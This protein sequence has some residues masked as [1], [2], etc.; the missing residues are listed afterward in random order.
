MRT[1]I[2]KRNYNAL[3]GLLLVLG[4][5][6]ITRFYYKSLFFKN[7]L[8]YNRTYKL[9]SKEPYKIWSKKVEPISEITYNLEWQFGFVII[10]FSIIS[11]LLLIGKCKTL[12]NKIFLLLSFVFLDWFIFSITQSRLDCDTLLNVYEDDNYYLSLLFFIPFLYFIYAETI[13]GVKEDITE[14][15]KTEINTKH[16][17][18]IKDLD[19]LLEL[20]LISQEEYNEKKEYRSKEKIRIEIKETEEYNLLLKSKQNGL[21]TEEEFN[22]KVENLVS[23][24]Y[25]GK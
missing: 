5:Y 22:K 3:I 13:V 2:I 4:I 23:T 15:I 17:D 21:L 19:K 24:K 1:I 10:F 6:L 11:F 25:K 12:K 18:N 14:E 16:E 7:E 20:N 8:N 9:Y